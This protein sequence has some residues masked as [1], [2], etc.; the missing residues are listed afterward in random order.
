M[1]DPQSKAE[2]SRAKDLRQGLPQREVIHAKTKKVDKLYRVFRRHIWCGDFE[3]PKSW[4]FSNDWRYSGKRFVTAELAHEYIE[5]KL[6]CWRYSKMYKVE[7]EVR[8]DQ[9]HP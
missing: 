7:F 6:R 3:E 5:K 2:R 4:W 8:N 9:G 1:S